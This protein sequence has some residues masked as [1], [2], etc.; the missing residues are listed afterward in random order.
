M[1]GY[2]RIFTLINAQEFVSYIAICA[3]RKNGASGMGFMAAGA[4]S[5]TEPLLMSVLLASMPA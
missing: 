1:N 5:P 2:T 4:T 3:V